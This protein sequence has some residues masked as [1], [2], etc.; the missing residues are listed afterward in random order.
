MTQL[1]DKILVHKDGSLTFRFRFADEFKQIQEYVD[2]NKNT[3]IMKQD[4]NVYANV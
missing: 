1:I 4:K 3:I 2:E